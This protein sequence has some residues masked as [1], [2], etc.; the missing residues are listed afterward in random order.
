[1]IWILFGLTAIARHT[2]F[3]DVTR[4]TG[5][6][7]PLRNLIVEFGMKGSF[8]NISTA[9]VPQADHVFELRDAVSLNFDCP[10]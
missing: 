2:L 9:E 6:V 10:T 8:S 5:I 4:N 3:V 7:G 1:M